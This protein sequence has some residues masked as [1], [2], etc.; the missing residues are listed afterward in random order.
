MS[1][2]RNRQQRK[3]H[4]REFVGKIEER[5]RAEGRGGVRPCAVLRKPLA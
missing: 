5:F 1:D 3:G 2:T 4:G